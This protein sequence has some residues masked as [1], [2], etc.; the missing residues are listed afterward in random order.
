MTLNLYFNEATNTRAVYFAA[1]KITY[2]RYI[3]DQFW[4]HMENERKE[5]EYF[6]V[7]PIPG[8]EEIALKN[9]ITYKL[10]QSK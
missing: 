4:L 3:W 5:N 6:K 1:S 7:I 8:K 2:E 10:K 9:L